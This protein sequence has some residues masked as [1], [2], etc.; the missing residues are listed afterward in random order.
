MSELENAPTGDPV[1]AV[2]PDWSGRQLRAMDGQTLLRRMVGA[3][4]AQIRPNA[5]AFAQG[6]GDPEHV[7]QLRVGLRRLRSAAWAMRPFG[8]GLPPG[9]EA[10][11]QPVFDALGESRDRHVLATTLAPEL[12]A[13]GAPLADLRP[14]PAEVAIALA[15]LVRG[16]RFQDALSALRS[17]AETP[18]AVTRG[19]PGGEGLAHLA[20]RLRKLSRQVMRGA[21]RFDALPFE[22]QHQVRKR[23]KRLRYLAE[24]AAPAFEHA[25]VKAWMKAV[26]RAQDTLGKHVDRVLAARRFAALAATDPRAWFAAGWLRSKTERS[27]RA[28]RKALA[29]LREVDAFW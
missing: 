21:H 12:A 26:S 24:F 13:A 2:P 22:D 8:A 1:K 7:H 17:F 5:G 19:A 28:A 29:R 18:D 25:D 3:C 20:A 16:D 9:W 10:A 15:R 4:L 6:R 23:L 14:P 27:S 11:L